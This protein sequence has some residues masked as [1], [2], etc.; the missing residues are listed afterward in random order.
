[1]NGVAMLRRSVQLTPNPG[2]GN[3]HDI[4]SALAGEQCAPTKPGPERAGLPN[5]ANAATKPPPRPTTVPDQ[6][7]QLIDSVEQRWA[8]PR[9]RAGRPTP[10]RSRHRG[11]RRFA[12]KKTLRHDD[13][14]QQRRG[15]R[16][17]L[18]QVRYA[19]RDVLARTAEV[20]A[21]PQK[22]LA[23]LLGVSVRPLPRWLAQA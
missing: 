20:L 8:Q 17:A 16:V 12:P 11:R 6:V 10:T 14:G 7:A 2:P 5:R 22:T 15:V 21:T 13:A 1:M 19:V 4:I 9:H 23:E 18:E 3:R